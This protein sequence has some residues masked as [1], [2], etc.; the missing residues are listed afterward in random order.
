MSGPNGRNGRGRMRMVSFALPDTLYDLI[1]EAM[2]AYG[3]TNRSRFLRMAVARG[4]AE[5]MRERTGG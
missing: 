5:L 2:L 4:I 3:I 1:R